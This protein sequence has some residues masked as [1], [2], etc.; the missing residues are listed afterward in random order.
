MKDDRHRTR[1]L[2][3]QGS[4]IPVNRS[5]REGFHLMTRIQD[6]VHRFAIEYHPALYRGEVLSQIHI[7]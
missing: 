2:Y 5:A 7:G 6:E 1:G 3:F 4:E